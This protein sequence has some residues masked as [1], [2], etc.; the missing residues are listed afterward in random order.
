M[1][2]FLNYIH[3]FCNKVKNVWESSLMRKITRVRISFSLDTYEMVL[4][5]A[6]GAL[7]VL[8]INYGYNNFLMT[9]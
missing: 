4:V 3:L 9:I 8:A 1:N 5:G 2:S 6:K 7:F